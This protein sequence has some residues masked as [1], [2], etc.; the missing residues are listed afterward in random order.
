MFRIVV[1][2]LPASRPKGMNGKVKVGVGQ[3]D[4][5]VQSIKV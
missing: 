1:R 5:I 2:D 4:F 3:Q